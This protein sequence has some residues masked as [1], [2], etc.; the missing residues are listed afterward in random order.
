MSKPT[1][2]LAMLCHDEDALIPSSLS[3]FFL[4]VEDIVVVDAGASD[5][6]VEWSER[7]GARVFH[8]VFNDDFSAQKNFALEQLN[9][10]WVYFQEPGE[11]VEPSLLELIT[12]LIDDSQNQK[13]LKTENILPESSEPFDCFSFPRRNLIDGVQT[14]NYPDYQD[15]L[16]KNICKYENRVHETLIGYKNKAKVDYLRAT[17]EDQ[18]C[19]N[20]RNYVSN[21]KLERQRAQIAEI[22]KRYNL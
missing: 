9:T 4:I 10:D 8:R 20:I 11:K 12:L 7:M 3:Q 5:Q 19:F 2:G 22:E 17:F 21:A 14:Q 1:L 16:F 18:S 15:R 6:S 13:S